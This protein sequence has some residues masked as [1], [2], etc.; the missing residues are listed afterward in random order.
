MK[1]WKKLLTTVLFATTSL[2]IFTPLRASAQDE[3]P[4]QVQAIKDAGIFKVGIKEDVPH[5]GFLNPDTNE[6]EGFEIA[7]AKL[8]AEEITGSANNIEF[9]GVTPKTRG[10]LLDNGEVDVVIA[11]F[12][13]TDERKETYNFTEPYYIDEVGFL[14][15][16]EDNITDFAGLEGKTI[17]VPQSATT[18]DLVQTE[19][20][21]QGVTVKF[22]ELATY[23]ELKT[24]LT[25]KRIDAM[26]VDKSILAGYVD[27]NSSILN[28]GFSPQSYGV[29]SKKS[30]TE[31]HDYINDL[32]VGWLEDGTIDQ[33]LEDNGLEPTGDTSAE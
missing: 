16:N 20:D 23:P 27:E 31:L 33:L 18:K 2:G 8:I 11:T 6:H 4:E 22:S 29:A 13:I 24:A 7:L 32:I 14:V 12:T 5:F 3:L 21:A 25:S 10:P 19:A 30:N 28:I 26:S 15:R 1:K 9:T 17:G